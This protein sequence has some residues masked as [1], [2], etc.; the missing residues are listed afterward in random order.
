MEFG[1]LILM[2]LETYYVPFCS[3]S[4]IF[5]DPG[6]CIT[7]VIATCRKNFS[8]WESSFLWKLRC[9]WLKFLRRVAKTLVIQGPGEQFMQAF[10][11]HSVTIQACTACEGSCVFCGPDASTG[12]YTLCV[13]S[14]CSQRFIGKMVCN[15]YYVHYQAFSS[16]YKWLSNNCRKD[17]ARNAARI[18]SCPSSRQWLVIHTFD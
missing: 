13:Y 18:V 3:A 6:P 5:G 9:H 10:S 7:N 14:C 16:A 15:Y 1:R 12:V 17:M 11:D 4:H 2:K 8:Q